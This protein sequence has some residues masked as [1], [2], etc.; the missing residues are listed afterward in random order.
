MMIMKIEF[1]FVSETEARDAIATLERVRKNKESSGQV[2]E[3]L[4]MS[5]ADADEVRVTL[6][7]GAQVIM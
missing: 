7:S 3:I 5:L 4:A 2:L 6:A 1:G